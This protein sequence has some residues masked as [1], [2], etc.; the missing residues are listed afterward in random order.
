MARN[1]ITVLKLT[2]ANS[3]VSCVPTMRS[4]DTLTGAYVDVNNIDA[5]KLILVFQKTASGANTSS[6]EFV[7]IEDGDSKIGFSAYKLGDLTIEISSDYEN[8]VGSCN[9]IFAGPYETARFKDSD[10]HIKI[11]AT[12]ATNVGYVG[13]ILI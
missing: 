9:L 8:V 11:N 3:S 5:S 6:G 4:L 12:N 10:G 2:T 13:A 7:T 1:A